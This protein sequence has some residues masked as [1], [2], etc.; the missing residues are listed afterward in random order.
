MSQNKT[1]ARFEN[2]RKFVARARNTQL[3]G[4]RDL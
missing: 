1:V 2:F 3:L 4:V